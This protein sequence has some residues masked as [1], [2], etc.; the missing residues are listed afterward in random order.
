MSR[1]IVCLKLVVFVVDSKI[2]MF[3]F[4]GQA[5]YGDIPTGFASLP[6][7]RQSKDIKKVFIF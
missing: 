7:G 4:I 1:G 5:A 6:T 3:P 2:Q